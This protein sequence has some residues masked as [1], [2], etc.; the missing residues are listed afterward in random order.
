MHLSLNKSIIPKM[1]IP[2]KMNIL[3]TFLDFQFNLCYPSLTL[4]VC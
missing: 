1:P 2:A 4:R 3:L